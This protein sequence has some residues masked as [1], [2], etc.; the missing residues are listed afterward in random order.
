MTFEHGTVYTVN[1]PCG[2][3]YWQL[4]PGNRVQFITLLDEDEDGR[5]ALVRTWGK[6][7][8]IYVLLDQE[9]L[10]PIKPAATTFVVGKSYRKIDLPTYRYEVIGIRNELAAVW[11]WSGGRLVTATVLSTKVAHAYEE[12]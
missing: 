11:V 3:P 6:G 2:D 12:A 9:V 8:H 1:R 4:V 10:T 5:D 7:K